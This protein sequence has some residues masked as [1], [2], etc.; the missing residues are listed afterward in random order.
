MWQKWSLRFRIFLFFAFITCA[1]IAGIA[2]GVFFGSRQ[3]VEPTDL[4][5]MIMAGIIGSF[6]VLGVNA[7]VWLLFD[8]NVARPLQALS[9]DLRARSDCGVEHD[10]D[11]EKARYLGDLAPAAQRMTA[12]LV[13]SRTALAEAVAAETAALTTENERLQAV[14]DAAPVG[15]VAYGEDRRI[16]LYNSAARSLLSTEDG[17]C[18][19]VQVERCIGILPDPPEAAARVPHPTNGHALSVRHG[20]L[21]AGCPGGVLAMAMDG[22]ATAAPADGMAAGACQHDL[23]LLACGPTG[24]MTD[25]PLAAVPF[26]VFDTETTGM[27]PEAGDEI[28]QIA[29]VRVLNGR[30]LEA[31]RFD[32]LVDPGREIPPLATKIHGID[33]SML[34]GAPAPGAAIARFHRF[35]DATALIAHNAPFDL[36]FLKRRETE[37]GAAFDNPVLDTVLL[38]AVI[39]GQTQIE[40]SLDALATRLG[41]EIPEA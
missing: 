3:L 31:E 35:A 4:Q 28:V 39:W 11:A 29:G 25:W 17:L 23:S 40:H 18:L 13:E 7:W 37:I 27:A 5:A 14:L 2:A 32:L 33:A 10:L 20:A 12:N 38:S 15:L 22:E 8:E 24:P 16:A 9:T 1:G 6:V 30:V 36:A 21:S 41:V 26:T 19:G 34:V